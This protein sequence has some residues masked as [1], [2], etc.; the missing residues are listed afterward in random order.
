MK[1][2]L[3][4]C[5]IINTT[6]SC[7][8][9]CTCDHF[10][11]SC[12]NSKLENFPLEL[13]PVDTT[14]FAF[15]GPMN[16]NRNSNYS[17]DFATL[18]AANLSNLKYLV[19][20]TLTKSGIKDLIEE[21]FLQVTRLQS[22]NLSHNL[23]Q[24]LSA[25]VFNGAN[26]HLRV[27]D[28][29]HNYLTD[30]HDPGLFYLPHLKHLNLAYNSFNISAWTDIFSKTHV[31][32][33]LILDGNYIQHVKGSM[34]N[35]LDRLEIL[36]LKN[37]DITTV[38]ID[39]EFYLP[40]LVRLELQ[41]NEI[42]DLHATLFSNPSKLDFLYLD[43]NLI[44]SISVNSLAG[45]HLHT[46]SLSFNNISYINPDAFINLKITE[47][48][49]SENKL[50][51]IQNGTFS[52]LAF[53]L[54]KL[55]LSSNSIE[56]DLNI[57]ELRLLRQLN[58]SGNALSVIPESIHHLPHLRSLDL[59]CNQLQT[60]NAQD[61]QLI[62]TLD[63]VDLYSNTWHCDC[64]LLDFYQQWLKYSEHR[65]L[66]GERNLHNSNSSMISNQSTLI[67]S[68]KCIICSGPSDLASRS[69]ATLAID[70][71]Q[72]AVIDK[73]NLLGL[74]ILCG[75]ILFMMALL[76]VFMWTRRNQPIPGSSSATT[77][78]G[79]D[80][81]S[82]WIWEILT[83]K[84]STV[85]ENAAVFTSSNES[86]KNTNDDVIQTI[87]GATAVHTNKNLQVLVEPSSEQI[88]ISN[89]IALCD[90]IAA[91]ACDDRILPNDSFQAQ[92][93]SSYPIDYIDSNDHTGD[94]N[95]RVLDGQKASAYVPR[96]ETI[97]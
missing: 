47:L 28:L 76:L 83:H 39:F 97:V 63:Y 79:R 66:C 7:F 11:I 61:L 13:L 75:V 20:L 14:S 52:P 55:S 17:T 74:Y 26:N 58:L 40:H 80:R 25:E 29:S 50:G 54:L 73:D 18:H 36:S 6:G 93:Y 62:L 46:L 5:C 84:K 12:S 64:G 9:N 24:H 67:T 10:S 35:Y 45:L 69:L 42:S 19:H 91:D 82:S 49:L 38:N 43:H 51:F 72:C 1:I 44:D 16:W 85:I 33:T 59:S 65:Q 90:T 86:D 78:I 2:S 92:R 41:W 95:C 81:R 48:N 23:I 60:L 21:P 3:T 4:I 30:L 88:I 57:T 71:Q 94:T 68:T 31:V 34:F 15:T 32:G 87:S 37:C 77:L 96:S 56:N 70:L 53:T 89:P 22:L 8:Q 27:L